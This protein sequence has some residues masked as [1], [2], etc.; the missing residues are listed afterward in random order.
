MEWQ[1]VSSLLTLRR[2]VKIESTKG[3]SHCNVSL[4]VDNLLIESLALSKGI[5]KG[6]VNAL[7]A[8]GDAEVVGLPVLSAFDLGNPLQ[9]LGMLV[10][11]SKIP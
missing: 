11:G 7:L 10:N 6:C 5:F 3:L 9:R 2:S 1:G 8:H 4:G